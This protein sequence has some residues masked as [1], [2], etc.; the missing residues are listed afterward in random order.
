MGRKQSYK[1]H[2]PGVNSSHNELIV[3]ILDLKSKIKTSHTITWS[4]DILTRWWCS[5]L[6]HKLMNKQVSALH[7]NCHSATEVNES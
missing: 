3:S 7:V 1:S 6:I 2:K 4:I 5:V